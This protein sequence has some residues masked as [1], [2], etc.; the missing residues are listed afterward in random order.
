MNPSDTLF[1][2][3]FANG[4][5]NYFFSYCFTKAFNP[6]IAVAAMALLVLTDRMRVPN[7]SL[8]FLILGAAGT[9]LG[10]WVGFT[11][12][13]SNQEALK[14]SDSES[15]TDS[16]NSSPP[17]PPPPP[18]EPTFRIASNGKDIGAIVL[19]EIIKM[20]QQGG[21][22][23]FDHFLDPNTNCWQPIDN[24]VDKL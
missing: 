3:C 8:M 20:R 4:A 9:I 15:L 13:S 1:L 10:G 14:S 19:S 22:T 5:I 6:A 23:K 11:T 7:P 2:L 12:R 24:L 21:L 18:H 17:P 16:S